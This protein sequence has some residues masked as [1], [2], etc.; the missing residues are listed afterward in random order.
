MSALA[1]LRQ[2][3]FTIARKYVSGIALRPCSPWIYDVA[4]MVEAGLSAAEVLK[5]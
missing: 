3:K 1:I 5:S 2:S 4:A